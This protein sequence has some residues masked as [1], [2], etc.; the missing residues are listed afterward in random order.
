MNNSVHNKL[1]ISLLVVTQLCYALVSADDKSYVIKEVLSN[2]MTVLIRTTNTM[3]RV[4]V[5]LWYDVGSKHEETGEHGLAHWLEHMS[6]KGTEKLSE[7]DIFMVTSKLAGI[8]NATTSFD[9]TRYYMNLPTDSWHEVLP[10]MADCMQHCTLKEDMLNSELKVVIQELKMRKDNYGTCMYEKLLSTVFADHPYH[11]PIIGYKHDL[12]N[13]SRDK[14]FAFY[15]QH[16]VPNNAVLVVVGNVD[17]EKA[18]LEIKK[19]FESIPADPTYKHKEFYLTNDLSNQTISIYKDIKQPRIWLAFSVP[20]LK[21]IQDDNIYDV[22]ELLL[23]RGKQSRLRKKLVDDL[24]LVTALSS[25]NFGL[26]DHDLFCIE[27]QPKDSKDIDTIVEHIAQEISTLGTTISDDE[28]LRADKIS[29]KDFYNFLE[30]NYQQATAIGK[31]FLA[32]GDENY[33]FK[34]DEQDMESLKNT[35]NDFVTNYF[36]PT[37]MHKVMMLPLPESEKKHWLSMQQ[38]SDQ[39]DAEILAARVRESEVEEGKYVHTVPTYEPSIKQAPRPQK[40]TLENG[41]EVFYYHNASI[42]TI[43][44]L[45]DLKAGAKYDSDTLPGLYNMLCNYMLEGTEHYTGEQLAQELESRAISL[46]ISP[47]FI[48]M[49]ML[50]EDLPKALE[51]L[52]EIV[53]KATFPEKSCEKIRSWALAHYYHFVDDP[54][55]QA[56]QRGY[57]VLYKGHPRAKNTVGTEQ[58][59]NAIQ[60]QD[61][62]DFYKKY[63]TPYKA[64][65]ALVGDIEA[66][67]VPEQLQK[68]IGTWQ[69]PLVPD[70]DYPT[71][72][73]INKETIAHSMNRDQVILALA[74]LSI[75]RTDDDFDKLLIFDYI[76]GQGLNSR[77]FKLREQ[78][79]A[80]YSISGSLV[81]DA[82]KQPGIVY[83]GTMVSKDRVDEAITMITNTIDTVIDTITQEE[84][85][86][87][88]R[89]ILNNAYNAYTTNNA[90]ANTFLFLDSYKL[91]DNY[92][93]KRSEMLAKIT[94]DDVKIAARKVLSSDAMITIKVGRIES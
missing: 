27:F 18:L 30:D 44:L 2:G 59:I 73:S 31:Y 84:V 50:K 94:L 45:L 7:A 46:S 60:R 40:T 10:I 42:P 88:K 66:Y 61:V 25:F 16:Y 71:L 68:T 82:G 74:G 23:T 3:Q 41:I 33:V 72:Q 5:Q 51:L 78:S 17:P 26:F 86:D 54:T 9:W 37:L 4:S 49:T 53:S 70:I 63:I 76:F 62:I 75:K 38:S 21:K 28:L 20:G 65:I 39:E 92:Y 55:A 91:P 87:A 12:Y 77:L 15:K 79:G 93:E 1:L 67:N 80:F 19:H 32:T 81:K 85:D 24:N 34:E 11:H 48:K 36:R 8:A 90:M 6:F 47:G 29:Q 89:M 83:V 57:E 69:G 22:L 43:T 58:S 35:L 52:E 13:L 64:I 56:W 14:L